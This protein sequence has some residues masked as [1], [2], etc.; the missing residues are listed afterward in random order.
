MAS[1]PY[2]SPGTHTT[3]NLSEPPAYISFCHL[4]YLEDA[5]LLFRLPAFDTSNSLG[6]HYGLALTARQ[7]IYHSADITI[8][9]TH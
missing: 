9:G 7:T 8:G 2:I 4:S 1:V 5:H 6:V 3:S